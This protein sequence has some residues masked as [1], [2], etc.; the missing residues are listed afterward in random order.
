M[1]SV[2]SIVSTCGPDDSSVG[3]SR[4]NSERYYDQCCPTWNPL[5]TYPSASGEEYEIVYDFREDLILN[6]DTKANPV[7]AGYHSRGCIRTA[8]EDQITEASATKR[9]Q[10]HRW[11]DR[12]DAL[13]KFSVGRTANDAPSSTAIQNA[14]DLVTKADDEEVYPEHVEPSAMG[15][16]GVTFAS[17]ER[18]VVV[19]FYNNG[20]AHALFAD[21]ESGDM[22][23]K[24]VATNGDG[25]RKLLYEVRAY[26]NGN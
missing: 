7:I 11:I 9:S 21:D 1:S 10:W 12:L 20:K 24:P 16:A 19:E 14:K 5:E 15:G 6:F 4:M 22:N 2:I 8:S 17:G 18:E 26:L 13:R 3:A 25:Y 23:T